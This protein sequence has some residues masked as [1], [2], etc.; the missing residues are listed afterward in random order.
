MH[1]MGKWT[2]TEPALAGD[3]DEQAPDGGREQLD[4]TGE[5]F[6][7]GAP[8]H[9]VRAGYVRRKAD[10]LLYDTVI[11]GRYAHVLAPDRTGKSS[12][13][14]ATAARLE[15]NGCKVA[16]LDLQQIGIRDGGGRDFAAPK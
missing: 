10:D 5:F 13:V 12:L 11:S 3:I 8:L 1:K 2:S 16:V 7:V 6:S 4:A 14:A 9:P 15:N